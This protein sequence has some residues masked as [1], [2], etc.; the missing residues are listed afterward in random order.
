[1]ANVKPVELRT[2]HWTK[3]EIEARKESE[4]KLKGK[5]SCREICKN[6]YEF[7]S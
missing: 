2:G 6:I 3:D 7:L 5:K 4:N 1:M